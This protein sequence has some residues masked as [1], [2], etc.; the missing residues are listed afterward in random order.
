MSGCFTQNKS[1]ITHSAFESA[2][3]EENI[4]QEKNIVFQRLI[5]LGGNSGCIIENLV[6]H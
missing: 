1:N 5:S 4:L 6:D 2:C 3:P